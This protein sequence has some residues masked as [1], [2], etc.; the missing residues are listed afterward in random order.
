[1]SIEER[2]VRFKAVGYTSDQWAQ[3]GRHVITNG[4]IP[5]IK[6]GRN[7]NDRPARPLVP[8]YAQKKAKRGLP[9][10]RNMSFT[11][12]TLQAMAVTAS[13]GN[14]LTIGFTTPRASTIASVNNRK[15]LQFALSTNDRAMGRE[16]L[17][18]FGPYVR[19]VKINA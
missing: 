5:R 9:P 13:S 14:G 17:A 7:A 16:K 12:K 6:A 15:D 19:A 1:M 10:V 4:M 8:K 2:K 11:G 3:M 18:T